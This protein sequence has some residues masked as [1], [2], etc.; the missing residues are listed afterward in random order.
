MKNNESNNYEKKYSAKVM[1]L[2]L[3]RTW[4]TKMNNTKI[5]NNKSFSVPCN[6]K[7]WNISSHKIFKANTSQ[8]RDL[9]MSLSLSEVIGPGNCTCMSHSPWRNLLLLPPFVM[10]FQHS[11][12][13]KKI[14]E[15]HTYNYEHLCHHPQS[16]LLWRS[17]MMC[18][19]TP[20]VESEAWGFSEDLRDSIQRNVLNGLQDIRF[21]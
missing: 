19:K 21:W 5:M 14:I 20:R 8:H 11:T 17:Y 3:E 18:F 16:T 4:T 7:R 2:S 10:V 13:Q 12:K 9:I 15:G 6:F 1:R